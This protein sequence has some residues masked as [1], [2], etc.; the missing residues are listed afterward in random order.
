MSD[1]FD[2][3]VQRMQFM[4][5]DIE[6]GDVV[7]SYR[8]SGLGFAGDP[9]GMAMSPLVSVRLKGLQF[10]PITTLL[11]ATI[12]MPAFTTTLTAEDSVGIASN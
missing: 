1:A 11:F 9:S 4:K 8:G 10:R 6:S 5:P 3:I 7:I 2:L 12:T